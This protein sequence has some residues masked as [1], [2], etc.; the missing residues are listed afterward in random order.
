MLS[1]VIFDMDGVIVDSEPLHIK[2]EKKTLAP[3]GIDVDEKTLQSFM[4]RTS[5]VLLKSI[6]HDYR[7][8]TTLDKIYPTH[9]ENLR[10]LYSTEL[11]LIPG[12]MTLL[13]DL[14]DAGIDMALASS[15]DLDLI[16]VVLT[17][18]TLHGFFRVVVSG[19]DVQRAK[20][21]PDIFL[22]TAERLGCLPE[23]CVVIEDSRAGVQAAKGAGMTCVG[24]RSPHGQDQDL[25]QADVIVKA[26]NEITLNSLSVLVDQRA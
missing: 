22:E 21:H 14:Q 2:A 9:K 13:S 10:H 23:A 4:G 17:T 19:E 25:D 11:R 5:R 24:F 20:P 7:L 18:F 6:I 1:A 12:I 3:Y 16:S 26:I 8:N 15:T